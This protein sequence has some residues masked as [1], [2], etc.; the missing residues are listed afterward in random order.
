MARIIQN[1]LLALTTPVSSEMRRLLSA[2]WNTLPAELRTERQVVGRA[3][4]H[5]G[6]TLGASYCSF[7]CT[8]CYLPVNANRTPLPSLADMK[9]QI[10]ANRRL[11]GP[12]GGLQITGGDVID[13]Y[14]RADRPD[15]LIDIVRYANDVG[16]VPMLMTHGQVL[17]DNPEYLQRLVV[18]GGLRKVGIHIDIT[19]AGR[20]CFPIRTLTRESDLHPLRDAFVDLIL[21]VRRAAN[22][23]L[24]AAHLVTVTER[25]V[26]SVPDILQWLTSNPRHLDAFR[27]LS[28]QTE[29]QVGRTRP[30]KNPVSPEQTWR[31]ICAGVNQDLPRDG[32]SYGHPDCTSTTLLLVL[33]PERR[34]INLVPSDT[35]SGRF[36]STLLRV[37]GGT[38]VSGQ[39]PMTSRMRKFS[40]A[41]RH[42]I[43]VVKLLSYVR[44]RLHE[45]NLGTEVL[46]RMLRGQARGFNLIMHNFIDA[47]DLISPHTDIVQQ[48]LQA[49]SFRGAIKRDGVWVAEPMCTMN[50]DHRKSMYAGQIS[51]A[52]K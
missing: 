8:H 38:G 20:P 28:F 35:Q 41:L 51:G 46:W 24:S 4:V 37:F 23:P 26:E 33:F 14:W 50:V 17:L 27:T 47:S 30:A 5:C 22:V 9:A 44:N 7:G 25:N 1:L 40:I 16:T 10:D 2:R 42:P 21:K 13:A 43:V 31:A 18:E 48:R 12:G 29:A 3:V 15:E 49:C 32:L 11:V 39:D 34:V 36:W 45:E 6:Y 52:Y 19:Q